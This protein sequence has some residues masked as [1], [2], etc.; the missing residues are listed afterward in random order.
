MEDRVVMYEPGAGSALDEG[1]E[2]GEVGSGGCGCGGRVVRM[3]C[4]KQL[5]ATPGDV[6]ELMG[7][8][9]SECADG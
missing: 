8:C 3:S 4:E 7:Y 6:L 2:S 1:V 5:V 9:G